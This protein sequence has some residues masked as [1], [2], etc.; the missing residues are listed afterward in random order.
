MLAFYLVA[1]FPTV[2][3]RR[4]GDDSG[5]NPCREMSVFLTAAIVVSAFGLPIVLARAPIALPVVGLF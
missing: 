5:S 1:P 3:S 4:Y 2:I